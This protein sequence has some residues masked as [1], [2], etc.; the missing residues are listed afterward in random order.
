MLNDKQIMQYDQA[1]GKWRNV[2]MPDADKALSDLTDVDLAGL[3]DGDYLRWSTTEQKW[4]PTTL[5]SVFKVKGSVEDFEHL[6]STDN[7]IGDV[8]NVLDT[9][10]NY[11]WTGTVWDKL[12][13]TVDL[14]SVRVQVTEMPSA[15]GNTG[16]V[17]QYVGTTTAN[18]TNGYF[19]ESD[20]STWTQKNVQPVDSG[21]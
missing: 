11:V 19:Y 6:P 17:Y 13:E 15:S 5:G 18:Y 2:D 20:G 16:K 10:A 12:S 14:E 8:Y 21:A 3:Q 4:I 9:G 1:N 7:E